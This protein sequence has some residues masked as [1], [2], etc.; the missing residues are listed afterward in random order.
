MTFHLQG[1]L[2]GFRS[3][4]PG[5][6]RCRRFIA[7]CAPYCILTSPTDLVILRMYTIAENTRCQD[8]CVP[9]DKYADND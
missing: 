6:Q 1:P 8:V 2:P 4:T 7:H 5:N 3:E 9:Q